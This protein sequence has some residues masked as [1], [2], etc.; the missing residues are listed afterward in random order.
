MVRHAPNHY[1][2]AIMIDAFITDIPK[3]QT[4][5]LV[6][7]DPKFFPFIR[8]IPEVMF[9]KVPSNNANIRKYKKIP[10]SGERPI[11]NDLKAISD[12]G[13]IPKRVAVKC[14][15]NA[16]VVVEAS[17]KITK[18]QWK[19]KSKKSTPIVVDEHLEERTI[20]V[21]R[22]DSMNNEENIVDNSQVQKVVSEPIST[23]VSSQVVTLTQP[24]TQNEH[25]FFFRMY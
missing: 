14:K 13:D 11:L 16:T 4:F 3:M 2:V 25:E 22:G 21:V 8:S 20:S 18:K 23:L 6:T 15:G 10:Y 1:R 9:S 12:V 19:M 24:Y 7:T 17:P 5:D